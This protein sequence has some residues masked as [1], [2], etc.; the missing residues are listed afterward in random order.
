MFWELGRL[1]IHNLMRA[2]A[3]L[4]MTS[5]GV[6]VGTAA[7]IL[8]VAMTIGLQQAAE[9]G[10]GQSGA[11]T[12]VIVSPSF[13][14]NASNTAEPPQLTPAMI[15]QFWRISGVRAVIP[16]LNFQSWGELLAEDYSG[17]G[18]ILGVD[19]RL[20]PYMGLDVQEGMLSL[21]SGQVLIGSQI[22]YNFYDPTA[23]EY[24]PV[25]V[26]VMSTRLR[27]RIYNPRGEQRRMDLRPAGVLAPSSMFDYAIIMPIEQVIGL[28][29]WLNGQRTDPSD[30]RYDLVVIRAA[31]REET[32]GISD[33]VKALGFSAGGLG[34]FINQLNGF[35]TTMRLVLGGVGGVAL[36]VA[37]FGVANTMTMAILERTREIGLMKA[38]GATDRD[39]LTIFLVEA[40]MVGL[41][42][43][44]TG[45]LLSY[46]AGEG[47]NRGIASLM[48]QASNSGQGGGPMFLPV[49]I[50]QLQAGLVIIPTEL[51]LFGLLLATSVGIVAGLLPALRAAR[52][53]TVVALKTD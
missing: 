52:M 39:V 3:R 48:Q 50:S 38:V 43:G 25:Q 21:E 8:L 18:Q 17:G 28:N 29:E 45:V 51:A 7:V 20:L 32:T 47:I 13:E 34:E 37:A 41:V 11:L 6:L 12:E 46:L 27:M 1:A 19:A 33:A 42:G 30:F 44:V 31:S 10:I 53:T 49:D 35:F 40:A 2:R 23:T 5:G 26:D 36:L 4:A 22:P 9:Q 16:L 15:E 24:R 14:F